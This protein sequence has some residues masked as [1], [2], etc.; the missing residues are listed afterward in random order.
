MNHD[1]C[2]S[3][4]LF[5]MPGQNLVEHGG[6]VEDAFM[7]EFGPNFWFEEN[8]DNSIENIR[9]F[10]DLQLNGLELNSLINTRV[11]FQLVLIEALIDFP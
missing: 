9:N 8:S 4:R 5:W 3:T 11:L 1:N 7:A 10:Q 6:N 2:H